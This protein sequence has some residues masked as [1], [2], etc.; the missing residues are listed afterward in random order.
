M[1][2]SVI[3]S[4]KGTVQDLYDPRVPYRLLRRRGLHKVRLP[5]G[6]HDDPDCMG[7]S[8]TSGATSVRANTTISRR[9]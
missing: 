6:L 7:G 4:S 2:G 1:P 8:R 3:L 5:D 9:W